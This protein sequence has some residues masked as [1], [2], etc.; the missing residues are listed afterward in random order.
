MPQAM[1]DIVEAALKVDG[2]SDCYRGKRSVVRL[3]TVV[4]CA[5]Q[6]SD[7]EQ[8]SSPVIHPHTRYM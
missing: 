7:R 8:P 2:E 3:C 5:R 4:R 1:T 6:S